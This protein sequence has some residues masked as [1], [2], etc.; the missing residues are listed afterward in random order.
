MLRADLFELADLKDSCCPSK[1]MILDVS[2]VNDT[3]GEILVDAIGN[4]I[5]QGNSCRTKGVENRLI[6]TPKN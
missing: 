6:I 3:L 1:L 4:P 2:F 5:S